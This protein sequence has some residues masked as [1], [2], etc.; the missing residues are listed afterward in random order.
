MKIVRELVNPTERSSLRF[1]ALDMDYFDHP[2]HYHPELELTLIQKGRGSMLV[3]DAMRDYQPGEICLLGSHLP[4]QY[5]SL[6]TGSAALVIQFPLDALIARDKSEDPIP[7]LL[8][9]HR[10][11]HSASRGILI[12]NLPQKLQ[13]Q[14]H[15]L[16]FMESNLDRYLG[17]MKLLRNLISIENQQHLASSV[18]SP[19]QKLGRLEQMNRL[20]SYIE[21]NAS[22]ELTL[23]M[24]SEI[25][26]AIPNP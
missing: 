6:T 8:S 2:Y 10:W 9:L 20:L 4:H 7:E 23:A 17:L 1:L 11:L 16:F 18:Y 14:M 26:N 5:R 3:G 15:E 22:E 13:D 24:A 21:Q 19:Q 25:E 12:E